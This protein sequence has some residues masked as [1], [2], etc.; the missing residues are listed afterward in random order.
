MGSDLRAEVSRGDGRY[1]RCR[2]R[3]VGA[4]PSRARRLICRE[5]RTGRYEHI[6]KMLPSRSS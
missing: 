2:S 3:S 5:S 6:N 4:F 1:L